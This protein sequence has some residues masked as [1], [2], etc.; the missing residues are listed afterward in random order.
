MISWAKLKYEEVS[1]V[2]GKQF[3]LCYIERGAKTRTQWHACI[4]IECDRAI[5]FFLRLKDL[6]FWCLIHAKI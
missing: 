3:Q 4:I 1:A 5:Y 2:I 6:M